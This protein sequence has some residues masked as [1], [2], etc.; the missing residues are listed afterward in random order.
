M[1]VFFKFFK[2]LSETNA[3]SGQTT[4]SAELNGLIEAATGSP[5][6]VTSVPELSNSQGGKEI[7]SV[8][9]LSPSSHSSPK[10]QKGGIGGSPCSTPSPHGGASSA[11]NVTVIPG[12]KRSPG[13]RSPL[14]NGHGRHDDSSGSPVSSRVKLSSGSPLV[15]K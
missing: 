10:S 5:I 9:S 12:A 14:S 2:Q 11:S 8:V 13:Q 3:E 1:W 6:Y 15:A 7:S 4:T